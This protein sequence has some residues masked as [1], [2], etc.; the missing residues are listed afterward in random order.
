VSF[1]PYCAKSNAKQ[2]RWGAAKKK[3]QP[4]PIVNTHATE[5]QQHSLE[6]PKTFFLANPPSTNWTKIMFSSCIFWLRT[7]ITQTFSEDRMVKI[8]KIV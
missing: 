4:V 2:A 8:C 5:A 3:I 7:K 1:F 6:I